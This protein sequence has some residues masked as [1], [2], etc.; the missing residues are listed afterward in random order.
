MAKKTNFDE[1]N[2]ER[3]EQTSAGSVFKAIET[4]ASRRGQQTTASPQEIETRRSQLQTQGR[5]G[6]KAVRINMAFTP[7]NH[8]FLTVMAKITGKTLTGF[9]NFA[10]DAYREEHGEVYEQAK[11]IMQNL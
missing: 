8:E 11:Q 7:E 2:T 6:A 9:C 1:I 5:K 4:G 3:A 10:L